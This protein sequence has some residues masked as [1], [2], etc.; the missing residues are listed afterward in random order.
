MYQTKTLAALNI[1]YQV[2]QETLTQDNIK[3]MNTISKTITDSPVQ[4][5][6]MTKLDIDSTNIIMYYDGSFYRK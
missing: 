4:E 6:T 5:L 2:I 3:Y 1:I